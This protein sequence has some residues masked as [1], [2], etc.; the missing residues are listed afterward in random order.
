MCLGGMRQVIEPDARL[1]KMMSFAKIILFINILV[2]F[3][4][5]FIGQYGDMFYDLICSLFLM[6]ASFT[7]YFLYMA[8]YEIFCLINAFTLTL[9]IAKV[10]QSMLQQN[11]GGSSNTIYLSISTVILVFYIFAIVFTYPMYREMRAQ[12]MESQGD[13]YRPA[14]ANNP[15]QDVERPAN[16]SGFVP[17]SGRGVAVGG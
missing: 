11:K 1:T 5:I 15:N 12:A 17:F 3:L 2:S 6:M 7:I 9:N 8:M 4:R 13:S 16:R 10:I 14:I